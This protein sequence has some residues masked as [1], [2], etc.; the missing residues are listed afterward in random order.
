MEEFERKWVGLLKDCE[1][2]LDDFDLDSSYEFMI[3]SN[4]LVFEFLLWL[5]LDVFV[6]CY[7]VI[8]MVK[9][10]LNLVKLLYGDRFLLKSRV[11]E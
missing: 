10:W 4:Y 2:N 3:F 6:K 5:V 8:D 7:N 1:L 11:K 9:E